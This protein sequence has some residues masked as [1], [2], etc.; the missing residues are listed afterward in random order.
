MSPAPLHSAP[1]ARFWF[2]HGLLEARPSAQDLGARIGG[3]LDVRQAIVLHQQLARQ[4]ATAKAA[5]TLTQAAFVQETIEQ[6]LAELRDAIAH[7]RFAS[8]LWRNP[9]PADVDWVPFKWDAIW[10]PYR[11]YL[12]D[13]QKQLALVL[14]RWRRHLRGVLQ[15]AGGDLAALGTIDAVY[16]QALGVKE[17]RLLASLPL[18]FEQRLYTLAKQHLDTANESPQATPGVSA[19]AAPKPDWLAHFES[20]LRQSLLAELDLRAQ[21]LLGMVEAYSTRLP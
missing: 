13:H 1:L 6:A 16:E 17:T 14:G 10:E 12:V 8:G 11:R 19:K 21:P 20:T 4:P 18:K 7:D 3:W 9:M 2:E 5:S 15:G